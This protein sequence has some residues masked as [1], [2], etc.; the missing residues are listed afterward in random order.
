MKQRTMT[1][2]GFMH[3]PC[4]VFSSTVGV[5]GYRQVVL[6]NF[7]SERKQAHSKSTAVFPVVRPV[8]LGPSV[9]FLL[10]VLFLPLHFILSHFW[11]VTGKCLG[12][13][14]S[15]TR[16]YSAKLRFSTSKTRVRCFLSSRSHSS[17]FGHLIFATYS[18]TSLHGNSRQGLMLGELVPSRTWWET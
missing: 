18:K 9:T 15:L 5:L 4:S 14:F 17:Y 1:V 3:C 7:V 2:L 13:C 11:M 8:L 16:L 6:E 12:C 10:C